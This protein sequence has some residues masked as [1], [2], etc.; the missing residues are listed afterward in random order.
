[1]RTELR[2]DTQKH[3][4][5]SCL[6]LPPTRGGCKPRQKNQARNGAD[7]TTGCPSP[8]WIRV[9]TR[10]GHHTQSTVCQWAARPPVQSHIA[11]FVSV[12]KGRGTYLPGPTPTLPVCDR[13]KQAWGYPA[14]RNILS[15]PVQKR[16]WATPCGSI[17]APQHAHF[18]QEKSWSSSNSSE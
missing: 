14:E 2:P 3:T 7:C 1:M 10:T 15:K 8:G 17:P 6:Q 9:A 18:T 13:D 12:P 16:C 5:L 11:V 4:P